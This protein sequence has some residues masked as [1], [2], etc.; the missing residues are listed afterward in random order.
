MQKF[1]TD[2]L[3]RSLT[4]PA[5]GRLSITDLREPGLEFRISAGGSRSWRVR[6]RVKGVAGRKVETIGPYPT[7]SLADARDRAHAITSAAKKGIDLPE[8]EKRDDEEAKRAEQ[9]PKT[10][11]DLLTRY[12]ND[13]CKANQ[14]RWEQTDRLFTAHVVPAIGTK[15]LDEVRRADIVELLD[16]LQNRKGL[17]AQV[18]RV[19]S[20]VVAAFNWA[21]ER[22]FIDVNPAATVKKRKKIETPRAR[23]LEDAE[24]VAIWRAA[25]SLTYPSKH[26]V[27]LMILTGQRRDE[28]RCLPW[29]EL[30]ADLWVLPG[31][32]NKGRRDHEIPLPAAAVELL[33]ETL[34]GRSQIG[35]FVFSCDSEGK[36]PYAGMKRLKIILDRESGVKGWTLHDIRRTVATGLGR[37]GVA[38]D[39][40]ERV[41]NHGRGILEK[42]YNVHQY[43]DEKRVALEAWSH[44]VDCLVTGKEAKVVALAGHAKRG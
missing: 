34:K 16:D 38:Q 29:A 5:T 43:R 6:Y 15:A 44:H 18:N 23:V 39:V 19:R 37:L 8:R 7:F 21:V 17:N 31:A 24:L 11:A 41:L 27:K 26:I 14:R 2:P 1:L 9:R 42:T 30:R 10:V 32:R 25:D 3:L 40:I 33:K 12:V 36:R 22:D 13:Y 20:Q 4:P 35:P 28:V